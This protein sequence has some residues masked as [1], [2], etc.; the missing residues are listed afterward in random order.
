MKDILIVLDSLTTGGLEKTL[1]DLCNNID[2]TKYNVDVYLFN[3]GRDLVPQLNSNVNLLPDS[4]YYS[5]VFNQSVFKSVKALIKQKRLDLAF[6]RI[7]RFLKAR[8]V[9]SDFSQEDWYF[10][11]KTMLKIDKQYDVAIGFAE[12]SACYYVAD[13]VNAKVKNMWIHT[14]IKE[15][16]SNGKLDT[17]AFKRA[18]NICT[19]SQNSKKSLEEIYPQF[20]DKIKAFTLPSLFDF[21]SIDRLADKPNE[22][23]KSAKCI[24]SV[25]RLVELKGF[26]L[27]IEPCKQLVDEGYNIKWY[28]CGEGPQRESLE[29]L[30]KQYGM[31]EHFILLGNKSNPYTYINSADA[32]VQPSSYEGLSLVIY[33]EKYFKKPIVCTG[34][35]SNLEM[36]A[37]GKNGLIVERNKESIYKAVKY[38]LDNP[39]MMEKLGNMPALNYVEKQTT[40]NE[41]EKTF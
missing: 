27:C 31:E 24:V 16:N 41:L 34:I 1:I 20:K 30:I 22:M 12:G 4:P 2:Y 23:D 9:K 8:L 3:D 37:H 36:I 5:M 6:Y 13:C 17:M 25:G 35:K 15:I 21:D 11:K 7:Y 40:I 26:H 33:E 19:V 18:N 38:L 10:Q 39:E 29:E 14:D 32:C 28:I